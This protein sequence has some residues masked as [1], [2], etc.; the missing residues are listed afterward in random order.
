[1]KHTPGP[2]IN[3]DPHIVPIFKIGYAICEV[4]VLPH[5]HEEEQKANARLIAAAPTMLHLLLECHDYMCEEG[6]F[7]TE[8]EVS[9]RVKDFLRQFD[10]ED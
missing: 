10:K 3:E 2:W 4:N 6:S 9:K 1:M 8:W 5:F 7:A